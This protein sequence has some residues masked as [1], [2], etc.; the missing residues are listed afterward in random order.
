MN[1]LAELFYGNIR[2]CDN[3]QSAEVRKKQNAATSAIE[4]LR[5]ALPDEA[6]RNELD[7][8]LDRQSELIALS[9]RDAFID[10]FKLGLLI[11]TKAFL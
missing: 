2:P 8:V 11:A 4:K 10:G 7:E 5:N 1:I 9:E 6:L 3:P